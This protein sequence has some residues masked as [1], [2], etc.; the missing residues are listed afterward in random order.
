MEARV[1]LAE[2][3]S[4]AKKYKLLPTLPAHQLLGYLVGIGPEA[5][6][7]GPEDQTLLSH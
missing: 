2:A 6:R 3:L 1:R 5:E 7:R 4:A